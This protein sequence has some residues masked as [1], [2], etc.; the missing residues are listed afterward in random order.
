MH[1]QSPSQAIYRILLR[2]YPHEFRARFASDL[3]ADFADLLHARGTKATWLRVVPDLCRSV[4]VT[5][6]R[7]RAARKRARATAYHGETAMGSLN[8]DVQH[9]VRA[10]LRAPIFTAVTVITL[11]L[12]IGANSAIFSLVNAVL[13]RPLGYAEPQRL[14]LIYEGFRGSPLGKIGVSPPDYVDLTTLQRSFSSIGAYRTTQYELSGAG[15]P[16]Q[17]TG[18]RVSASVFPILGVSA[19]HGR[20]FLES[21]DQPGQEV[22]VLSYGLWQRRFGGDPNAVGRTMILDR[23][24]YTIVGIMPASFQFPK[25]GPQINGVPAQIWTP[26]G[27]SSFERSQQARG[28][29]YNH[30][31]IGR[32]AAGVAAEQAMREV[33]A[34]G[35]S[36][37]TNYPPILQG[38]VNSLVVTAA[39]LVGE[40]AGQVQRPLLI[41]LGAVGL[42]LLVACANVANLVLS[43]AV[44]RQREISVRAALGAGRRRLLQMLLAETLL[45]TAAGGV[46]GLFIGNAVV[47][48]IPDVITLSLPGV[49]DVR[50][51]VR[52]VL[53]TFALSALTAIF[54]GLLPLIVSERRDLTDLLREGGT[55]S[56]GGARHYRLQA[57]LVVSSVALAVVLLASAGLLMRSFTRLMAVDTGIRAPRVL[58]MEVRLP[59]AGYDS[60]PAVRSFYQRLHERVR[61]IPSVRAASIQTDLPLKGD[62]ERRAFTADQAIDPSAA[63]AS[64][65]VTWTFGDYFRTFGVPIVKG[66]GFLPEEDLDNRG[67]AIVSRAL[68]ER[69]WPGQ[70]PIGK[71][72]KWGVAASRAPW[73]TV[74]GVAGDVVDGKL[75]E[76]PI[77]HIY[78]PFAEAVDPALAFP[79]AGLVRRMSVAA[80]TDQDVAPLIDPMRAAIATLDPALAVAEVTTMAHVMADASAP[81]RFSTVL[82]G[83]FASGALLLAA[84]GLYGMLAFGVAR[85][86]REIGVRLALGATRREVLGLVVRQGMTLTLAGLGLGIVG[87][88]GATRLMRGL[89][90]QTEPLDPVTFASV[91][92]ILAVV[93]LCACYLPARRAASVEP[94]AALRAE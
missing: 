18:V 55:R 91:P 17:I 41:L 33:G 6:A 68:A 61:A 30:T 12:G 48:A 64:T 74:V 24:P 21:E 76:P 69:Y 34:L 54:F 7:A 10:L 92:G 88:F 84:I 39:P 90:F 65:A 40:I 2:V 58:T 78:V 13:L 23:R 44:T 47:R 5:H 4:P 50:L 11:A 14:M 71:R 79:M 81:Q 49:Q 45:L 63:T 3:E 29:M 20:A 26:L 28:M 73:Q 75:G 87:A 15:E 37:V 85:R 27:L 62:G 94:M 46:L 19:A 66:R 32:L 83:A 51:D 16:E 72:L 8:A 1:R 43:R 60:R 93:A 56:I 67:A 70:D 9:A 25:R 31:V 22:A 53:F 57:A 89:L 59:Q 86:T 36:L 77:M 80:V 38:P 42:V 52:V 82:L 35:P